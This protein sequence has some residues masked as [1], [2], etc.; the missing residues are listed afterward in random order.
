MLIY[1]YLINNDLHYILQ[2][3]AFILALTLFLLGSYEL[4]MFTS[5]SEKDVAQTESVTIVP[6]PPK[7][8][9]TKLSK[10]V[11]IL[12]PGHGGKDNGCIGHRKAE[13]DVTLSFALRLG[14][15]LNALC[16]QIEVRYT[17]HEDVSV[18][19]NKRVELAN[20][21]Q[22]D[23]FISIHANAYLDPQVKGFET[24]VYGQAQDEMSSIISKRENSQI[25]YNYKQDLSDLIIAEVEKADLLEK[26]IIVAASIDRQVNQIN[27]YKN[28]GVKQSEFRVLKNTQIPSL[29]LEVGYLTNRL[30]HAKL[31]NIKGQ[32]SISQK[33]AIGIIQA[34]E[35]CKQMI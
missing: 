26:S 32:E 22:A 1:L 27:Q 21:S 2:Y 24:Y 25:N 13:K 14:A 33:V 23:L 8:K 12:D 9:L 17:R 10:Y 34:I 31:T 3:F 19:L 7:E 20:L 11:I 35:S 5:H 15:T 6:H 18:P 29:L 16:D 4:D 28:R 30:D